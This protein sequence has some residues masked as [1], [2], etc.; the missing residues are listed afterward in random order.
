MRIHLTRK[1][2]LGGCAT[3][4]KCSINTHA[5]SE[6]F[7]ASGASAS[8]R[9]DASHNFIFKLNKQN[10]AHICETLLC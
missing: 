5:Y 9:R 8:C 1:I 3:N 4:K 10:V 2:Y 6:L 7:C